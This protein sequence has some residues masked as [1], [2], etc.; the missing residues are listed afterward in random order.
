MALQLL[1]LVEIQIRNTT[2]DKQMFESWWTDLA[3]EAAADPQ[4]A[5]D[6]IGA[7]LTLTAAAIL[8]EQRVLSPTEQLA[9]Y[10]LAIA[11]DDVDPVFADT[12]R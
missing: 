8:D 11:N 9:E 10:R 4:A 6:L 1:A 5:A 3:H 2:A 7:M 12:G